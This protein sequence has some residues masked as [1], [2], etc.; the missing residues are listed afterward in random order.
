LGAAITALGIGLAIWARYVLGQ[1]WSAAVTLK[2]SHELVQRGPYAHIRHPIYSGVLLG[3]LGT[4]LAVGEW[5]GL[6]AVAV[7]F[8]S[9]L[10]KARKEE[11]LLATEFGPDFVEHCSHT[12]MFLPR[13]R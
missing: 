10:L 6:V 4:A 11:A 3:L 9:W 1:N 5:G 2:H 8:L 13:F 7:L 12:G